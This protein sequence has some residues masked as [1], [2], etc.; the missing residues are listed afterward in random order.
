MCCLVYVNL[1]QAV[2]VS[3]NFNGE[4]ICIRCYEE[5]SRVFLSDLCR[6]TKPSLSDATPGRLVP[7]STTKPREQ[8]MRRQPISSTLQWP[9]NY[10]LPTDSCLILFLILTSFNNRLLYGNIIQLILT[11]LKFTGSWY[12]ILATVTILDSDRAQ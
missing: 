6:R 5:A 9:L 12:F 10:C 3:E 7:G 1:T 2:S 4:I 11:S 8:A